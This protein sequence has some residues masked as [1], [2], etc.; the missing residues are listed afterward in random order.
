MIHKLCSLKSLF[1]TG[2]MG[3][4]R[5]IGGEGGSTASPHLRIKLNLA[6]DVLNFSVVFARETELQI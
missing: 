4:V 6:V 2:W 3:V 1:V 5:V